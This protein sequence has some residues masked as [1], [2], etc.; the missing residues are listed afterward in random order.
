MTNYFR[1]IVIKKINLQFTLHD[2]SR[3]VIYYWNKK[4]KRETQV[5][6][7][8]VRVLLKLYMLTLSV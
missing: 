6:R 5:K 4:Q 2:V 1:N 3:K 7:K 8:N